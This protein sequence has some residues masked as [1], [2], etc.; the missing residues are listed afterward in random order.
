MD[1]LQMVLCLY[2]GIGFLV[3]VAIEAFLVKVH[4][5]VDLVCSF[6]RFFVVVLCW[7]M[8]AM[9]YFFDLLGFISAR[10]NK[11]GINKDKAW[12]ET[13]VLDVR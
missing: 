5:P 2:F 4:E 3:F 11:P 8:I 10:I 12:Q 13:D 7:P 6:G 1:G 9:V